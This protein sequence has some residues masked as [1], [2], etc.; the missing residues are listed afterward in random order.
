MFYKKLFAT[1][2]VAGLYTLPAQAAD[3]VVTLR[4][5]VPNP[6]GAKICNT[7]AAGWAKRVEKTS[8][9]KIKVDVKC[10]FVLSKIGNTFDRVSTGVADVGWDLP[11]RYGKR[12]SSFNALTLPGLYDDVST[13]A[14]ALWDVHAAGKIGPVS[15]MKNLKLLWFNVAPNGGLFMNGPLKDHTDLDGAKVAVGNSVRAAMVKEMGGVPLSLSVKEYYQS[16][17]KGAANG[18]LT[19]N[20]AVVALKINEVTDYYVEGP[21]GGGLTFFVMNRDKYNSL[22]P[23]LQTVID[24]ASG[25][26]AS[27][28]SSGVIAEDGAEKFAKMAKGKT[29]ISLSADEVKAWQPAFDSATKGWITANPEGA[30]SLEALK[31]A[32]AMKATK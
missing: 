1:A 26:G 12:F 13:M 24:N 21:F 9:G 18:T 27:R 4:F 17:S 6:S 16:I 22:S 7:V 19:T 20:T 28:W 8:N 2:L 32:L 29:R 25:K 23:E 10:D 11:S 15:E 3:D 30:K 31:A 5:S 14:E